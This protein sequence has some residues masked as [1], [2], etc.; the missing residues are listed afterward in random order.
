MK[1]SRFLKKR[2]KWHGLLCLLKVCIDK[3]PLSGNPKIKAHLLPF[4]GWAPGVPGDLISL[5]RRLAS[6]KRHPN[7]MTGGAL[8]TNISK[9]AP[10]R[11]SRRSRRHGTGAGR[12]VFASQTTGNRCFWVFF[13]CKHYE[14]T[15]IT[16]FP[17][18]S[19]KFL[20]GGMARMKNR[21]IEEH[22]FHHIFKKNGHVFYIIFFIGN[23]KL[24]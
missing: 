8:N 21:I 11:V 10:S 23:N 9:A 7:P 18:I 16:I 20:K 14:K 1:T 6:E 15:R 5:R 12:E 2:S 19:M 13:C 3:F 22:E 17:M 4:L 24:Y